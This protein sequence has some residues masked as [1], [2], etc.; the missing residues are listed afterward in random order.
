MKKVIGLAGRTPEGVA[1]AGKDTVAEMI[2]KE[3]GYLNYGLADPL[4][5]M[6]KAGFMIDGKT[7]EWQNRERKKSKIDW[8]S[9]DENEVSLRYLL[10]TLGTEWGRDMVCKDLWL[11]IAFQVI[12]KEERGVIIRDIRFQNEVDWLDSV[13]G[14]LVHIIRPNYVSKD[15]SKNHVSNQLLDIREKD[16]TI[17]NDSSLEVLQKRVYAFVKEHI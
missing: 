11:R 4:Y 13:G 5:A 2:Q 7:E 12:K 6:V 16:V 10:E 17:M 3:T 9:S 8:L 15:A 1:G 14:I